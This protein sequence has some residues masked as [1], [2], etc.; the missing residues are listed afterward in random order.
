L[1]AFTAGGY[2]KAAV[3]VSPQHSSFIFGIIN[4]CAMAAL[5]SGSILIPLIAPDNSFDQW[6]I[7]FIIFIVV[8]V[9][10]NTFF[11]FCAKA[12]PEEW[13]KEKVNR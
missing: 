4:F 1:L 3:L 9:A 11:I 5:L 8:L 10:S 7:V 2:H 12:A 6:K 13:A